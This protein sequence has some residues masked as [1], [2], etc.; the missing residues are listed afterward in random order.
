MG[1]SVSDPAHSRHWIKQISQFNK[2]CMS[3][4]QYWNSSL[5]QL[6]LPDTLSNDSLEHVL[7]LLSELRYLNGTLKAFK[8]KM[9]DLWEVNA[10]LGARFPTQLTRQ[11]GSH[12][13]SSVQISKNLIT[14]QA[15]VFENLVTYFT[16]WQRDQRFWNSSVW[17]LAFFFFFS[18]KPN[19]PDHP[20]YLSSPCNTR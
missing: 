13:V 19:S 2:W 18:K 7:L 4:T 1:D 16:V 10:I 15:K 14:G 11:Q 20:F 12:Y 9:T 8:D 6:P 17:C 3:L 5:G